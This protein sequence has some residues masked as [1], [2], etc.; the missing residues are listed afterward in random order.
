[1]RIIVIASLLAFALAGCS[2]AASRQVTQAPAGSVV[3]TA[4]GKFAPLEVH[5]WNL[6]A[7]RDA[8]GHIAALVG[9]PQGPLAVHFSDGQIEVRNGCNQLGASYVR[10][11]DTIEVGSFHS[12][13]MACE[14]RLMDADRIITGLLHG[15]LK[16]QVQAG[17]PPTLI[18]TNSAGAE[19]NFVGVPGA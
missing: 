19:L 4:H 15:T 14:P 16:L 7:G 9:L 8:G 1:M 18:L 2:N 5:E 12:T 6:Q 11:G 13:R 3:P 10:K 17:T